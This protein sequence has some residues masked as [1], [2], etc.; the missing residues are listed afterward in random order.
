MQLVDY[1]KLIGNKQ[2]N[3]N[4]DENILFIN[5]V[6]LIITNN[7]VKAYNNM[8]YESSHVER[9]V[10]LKKFDQDNFV[11][12]LILYLNELIP[13]LYNKCTICEANI[14]SNCVD[15]CGDLNCINK[16]LNI[17][18]NNYVCNYFNKDE[19][20]FMLL[21]YIAY[22]CLKH[23]KAD[24]VMIPFPQ[25]SS[26]YT[27]ETLLNMLKYNI[28]NIN[29]LINIVKHSKNDESF[30]KQIGMIEYGFLKF[31]LKTNNTNLISSSL[32]ENKETTAFSSN[33]VVCYNVRHEPILETKFDNSAKLCY[34]FHGS[35]LGNW[36][37]I[38]RNGLKNCSGTELMAHGQAYGSGIY[39]SNSAS[40]SFGYG[41][42]K[43]TK[44]TVSVVGVLQVIGNTLINN[45]NNVFVEPTESNLLLKYILLIKNNSKCKEISNYFTKELPTLRENSLKL[46][47]NVVTKRLIHDS[48]KICQMIE[49]YG[50]KI[51]CDNDIWTINVANVC[52]LCVKFNQNYPVT[53]PFM[54]L[55][56]THYIS[57]DIT[58]FGAV[59]INDLVPKNWKVS[60]KIHV[61]IEN[62]LLN[63]E[64]ETK[65]NLIVFNFD[66][67]FNDYSALLKKLQLV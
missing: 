46:V 42:D 41:G 23:P 7:K 2:L 26:K 57:K 56:F 53:P 43:Y 61:L 40:L 4:V 45:N 55:N 5:D 14:L 64:R 47:A 6:G 21:I 27:S 33:D 36:Y 32:F 9:L 62:F 52:E 54:W 20:V 35:S 63:L 38:L 3:W 29:D 59:F 66:S 51:N 44:I 31:V 11:C 48:K 67:A 1:V 13:N 60:T 25:F 24:L 50:W 22:S 30:S 15:T 34:L 10:N 17:V 8:H 19:N 58:K 65:S 16:S 28:D 49:K 12:D 37:A 18:T 39:L